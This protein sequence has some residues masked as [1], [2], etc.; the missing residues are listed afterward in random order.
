[1]LLINFNKTYIFVIGFR[2]KAQISSL[3]K[4]IRPVGA[5]L[6]HAETD[7]QT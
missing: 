1:M 3:I 7:R 6:I 5:E 2:K 4:K